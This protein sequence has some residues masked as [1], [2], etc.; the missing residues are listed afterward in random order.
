MLSL[1]LGPSRK[2]SFPDFGLTLH[3]QLLQPCVSPRPCRRDESKFIVH[4]VHLIGCCRVRAAPSADR[5]PRPTTPACTAPPRTSPWTPAR[6]K[7]SVDVDC[8]AP[9]PC[10][11]RG[12]MCMDSGVQV[13]GFMSEELSG[14]MGHD[15]GTLNKI[16]FQN[17]GAT[18]VGPLRPFMGPCRDSALGTLN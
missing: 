6:S 2:N 4:V 1:I 11:G 14:S 15:L 8:M 17:F 13:H 3:D 10:S 18:A 5:L 9:Q 7:Y 16:P 12:D